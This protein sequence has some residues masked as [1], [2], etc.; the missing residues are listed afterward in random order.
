M[1]CA[2][3]P[4]RGLRLITRAQWDTILEAAKCSILDTL[5]NA[6]CDSYVLSE[7]SLFVYSHKMILKTCGTTTLLRC[8]DLLVEATKVSEQGRAGQQQDGG[9]GRPI[10][11]AASGTSTS[12]LCAVSPTPMPHVSLP[13][14]LLPHLC[15]F[16]QALGM[17]VEWLAY[18][19]KDFIFPTVQKFPHR[20][21]NE[22]VNYLKER[23]PEGHA[24]VMGP[25]TGDHWFVFVADYLDRSTD[26]C[27]DRT[28]DVSAGGMREERRRWLPVRRR[29]E[30]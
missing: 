24:F 1:L 27:V 9:G 14:Y 5:S 26:N 4:E 13:L 28:L 17:K 10:A 18:T 25:L 20:D 30:A 19:R 21:P 22:E 6:S 11:A 29:K 8:L 12:C 23:Y 3:G 16:A 7:S 2:V 15:S